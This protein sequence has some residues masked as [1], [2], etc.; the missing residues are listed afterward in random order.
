MGAEL[1][2]NPSPMLHNNRFEIDDKLVTY[3]Y[4]VS[5]YTL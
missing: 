2:T 1:P 3:L 5:S 4:H